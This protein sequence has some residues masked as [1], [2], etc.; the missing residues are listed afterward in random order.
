MCEVDGKVLCMVR[1]C[2]YINW[3]IG[4][5]DQFGLAQQ[6]TSGCGKCSS[7]FLSL[8]RNSALHQ[9]GRKFPLGPPIDSRHK[10]TQTASL[11]TSPFDSAPLVFH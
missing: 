9:N 8:Q 10:T 2:L 11:N 3:A 6:L 7:A 4:D 5:R 1:V